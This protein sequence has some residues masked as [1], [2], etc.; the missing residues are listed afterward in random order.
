MSN[1]QFENDEDRRAYEAML[2]SNAWSKPNGQAMLGRAV[3][4]ARERAR[5]DGGIYTV[6]ELVSMFEERTKQRTK[7]YLTKLITGRKI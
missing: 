2:A 6:G 4:R 1:N 3:L 7:E 5:G